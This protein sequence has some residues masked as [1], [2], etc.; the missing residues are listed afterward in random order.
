L[1]VEPTQ[2]IRSLLLDGTDQ[3]TDLFFRC[4]LDEV[5]SGRFS[6]A[7]EIISLQGC[8][9]ITDKGIDWM[10]RALGKS[11]K[12][13][14]REPGYLKYF[15]SCIKNGEICGILVRRNNLKTPFLQHLSDQLIVI[16]FSQNL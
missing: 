15:Y 12:K 13:V 10:S 5:D 9:G 14:S 6:P 1:K 3:L 11:L 7:V 16:N 2:Y 8:T 4:L